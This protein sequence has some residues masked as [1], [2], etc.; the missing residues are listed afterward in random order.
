MSLTLF[1]TAGT[2]LT[3]W[4][5]GGNL[6]R[7]LAVYRK[8]AERF[9]AVNLVSYGGKR[10]SGYAGKLPEFNVCPAAWR[11]RQGL[12]ALEVALRHG[13]TLARSDIFKTNQMRGA[14]IPL[15]LKRVFGKPLIVR[16][17][18]LHGYFTEKQTTDPLLVAQA[19]ELESRAFR[20]ADLI[21][22]TSAW[23]R[24]YVL[25]RYGLDGERVG[26]VP[27][28]VQTGHFCPLPEVARKYD[29][30]F[31]G[32]GTEQKNLPQ[33][34]KALYL[35]KQSGREV[36]MLMAGSCNRNEQLLKL[37][38]EHSL[39]VD[40]AGQVETARLPEVLNSARAFILPSHYEGHPKA[41]LEAMSCALP[42]IGADVDGIG[43]EISHGE[44]GYLC[45]TDAE[46]IAEA[47]ST[48]LSD[49]ALGAR[50]A[51]GARETVERKFSLDQVVEIES[52]QIRRLLDAR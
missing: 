41:L 14:Q 38:G 3:D 35:L 26:I 27:N 52:S 17:G 2:G 15:W 6:E 28:Y 20:A 34:L 32:R 21:F 9:G 25:E 47:I 16:C 19:H 7:E 43:Q 18:F 23:Q 22:L 12:T 48:V 42:C 8:L 45:R 44:N 5:H 10:D 33:L 51:R 36:R 11:R 30:V 40:F 49:T 13:A 29:L 24:A 50:I 39:A 46:S 1:F 4:D 37:V 31:V